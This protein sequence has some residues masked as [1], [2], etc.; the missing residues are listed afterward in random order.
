M[1]CSIIIPT[2]GR[3]SIEKAVDSVLNQTFTA[4]NF[5]VIVVN[6]SGKSLPHADWE[7]SESVQVIQTNKRERIF[8]RN[9]GAA[10]AR[11]EYL[12]FLDDDDWLLPGAL[13]SIWELVS[14]DRKAAWAYGGIRIVGDGGRCLAEVNSGLSG[15][16]FAQIMGGAWAPIQSSFIRTETFF[17]VGGYRTYILGTEDLDL[18]RRISLKGE[19]ANTDAVIACLLRGAYWHT[20]TDYD[21]AE[22]DTKRS[23]DE[24]LSEP[25]VFTSLLASAD[26]SYWRGRNLRVYLSTVSWNLGKR[27][28]AKATSRVLFAVASFLLSGKHMFVSDYWDGVRAHHPPDTLHFVMQELEREGKGKKNY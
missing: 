15:Y 10:I 4:E 22:A 7:E 16:C 21:R 18:C 1:F 19:F 24:I 20:S 6:D 14:Q 12:C 26:T 2:I 3:S 8:A 11:G 25:G 23:R 17:E 28:Y 9:S 5:E 13:Q 27:C